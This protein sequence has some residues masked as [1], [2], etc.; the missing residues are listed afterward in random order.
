MKRKDEI[1]FIGVLVMLFI[2]AV[3]LWNE[4]GVLAVILFMGFAAARIS[5][6]WYE[7]GFCG[8]E[9][10]NPNKQSLE[11]L[12]KKNYEKWKKVLRQ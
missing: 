9:E 7:W 10:N 1:R 12:A 11:D 3:I 8:G 6:D 4:I 5:K 2:F